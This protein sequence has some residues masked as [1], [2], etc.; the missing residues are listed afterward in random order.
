MSYGKYEKVQSTC[1][2]N[3]CKIYTQSWKKQKKKTKTKFIH[4]ISI[5]EDCFRPIFK[6]AFLS[7]SWKWGE[8]NNSISI[9]KR[10]FRMAHNV[11]G[12]SIWEISL[13]WNFF[14][15]KKNK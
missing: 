4:Q 10:S 8:N 13:E 7:D 11:V 1:E 6:C 5:A 2:C 14:E 3:V 9:E 15:K 12:S